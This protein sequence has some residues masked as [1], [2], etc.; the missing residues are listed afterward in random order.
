MPRQ[1]NIRWREQDEK[2]LRR[3]VRNFNDKLRRL[4]KKNPDNANILPQYW[5][6]STQ[7]FENRLSVQQVKELIG[8]GKIII[9]N[10]T[11]SSDSVEEVLSVL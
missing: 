11:C 10:L 5:N 8:K 7:Q 2:E 4:V 1:Y 3:V 9:G 6:E